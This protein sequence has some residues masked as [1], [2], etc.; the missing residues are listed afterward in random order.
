[1]T[2]APEQLV[3]EP[4]LIEAHARHD[5]AGK[6]IIHVSK[7]LA[8]LVSD[9]D[10]G[11][12]EMD[13]EPG[14][15]K[16]VEMPGIEIA[17]LPRAP[18]VLSIRLGEAIY[19]LRAALDYLVFNVAWKDSHAIKEG[20]QFPI[21]DNPQKFEGRI[22][23]VYVGR[24]KKG[25]PKQRSCKPYLAGVDRTHCRWIEEFQPYKGCN[26]SRLLRT[27]SNPDKHKQLIRIRN[28]LRVDE[29]ERVVRQTDAGPVVNVKFKYALFIGIN[30]VPLDQIL[31]EIEE[32]V[33]NALAVFDP[34]FDS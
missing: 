21:E 18:I 34:V 33:G 13:L 31:R 29:Q 6:H 23:G 8:R 5:R 25:R 10:A 32:G 17:S 2:R 15:T 20:T 24:D 14:S 27:L 30:E 7:E 3:D 11:S 19:N 9:F 4:S 22:T 16:T 1:M 12:V 28:V 26:W